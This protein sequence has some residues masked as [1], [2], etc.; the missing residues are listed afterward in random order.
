MKACCARISLCCRHTQDTL[1]QAGARTLLDSGRRLCRLQPGNP[2]TSVAPVLST[3]G[4][5]PPASD[6]VLGTTALNHSNPDVYTGSKSRPR[7]RMSCT[8]KGRH[9]SFQ[10]LH[11]TVER[12]TLADGGEVLLMAAQVSDDGRRPF[13]DDLCTSPA[14]LSKTFISM[15]IT[16]I[17]HL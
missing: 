16:Q 6:P 10:E 4:P 11:K 13:R 1:G 17:P 5:G 14:Y 12:P 9:T 3:C 2:S 15:L 8:P 7:D